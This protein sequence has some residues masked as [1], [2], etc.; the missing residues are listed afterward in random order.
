M[1]YAKNGK[2]ISNKKDK[3]FVLDGEVIN[4]STNKLS[5]FKFDK[6]DFDLLSKEHKLL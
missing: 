5:L 2:I 3:K 6:I 4:I 1:I